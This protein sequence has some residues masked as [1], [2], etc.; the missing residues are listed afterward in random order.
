MK[1]LLN[2]KLIFDVLQEFGIYMTK[3]VT[4]FRRVF[5]PFFFTSIKVCTLVKKS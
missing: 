2:F 1:K 5:Y 4:H 3:E